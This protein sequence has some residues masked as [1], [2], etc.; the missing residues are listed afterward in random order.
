MA[1][2]VLVS[3]LVLTTVASAAV[4]TPSYG[5]IAA[6]DFAK[7]L[8]LVHQNMYTG[9][10]GLGSPLIKLGVDTAPNLAH[11]YAIFNGV[12][13]NP[14]LAAA[15]KTLYGQAAVGG[16]KLAGSAAVS[17]SSM[18][19]SLMNLAGHGVQAG[20]QVVE[21]SANSGIHLAGKLGDYTASGISVGADIGASGLKTAGD[22]MLAGSVGVNVI[23]QG[24]ARVLDAIGGRLVAAISSAEQTASKLLDSG[25][26]VLENGALQFADKTNENVY[27]GLV[28][29]V[30]I[31]NHIQNL[32]N[33]LATAIASI[34]NL[35]V[36]S[37]STSS[38]S[39]ASTTTSS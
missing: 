15:L 11:L 37:S 28:A 22:T 27:K 3:C 19:G 18:L 31:L 35:S 8:A 4:E 30:Q 13:V 5:K 25:V 38:A 29:Y 12:N 17:G 9:A 34:A 26:K 1:F 7:N 33:Q 21:A 24:I 6:Q 16:G 32:F 23:S 20:G 14:A 39:S 2:T 10:T 36:S